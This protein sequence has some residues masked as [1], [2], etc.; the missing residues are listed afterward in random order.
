M[1]GALFDLSF[2]HM[3]TVKVVKIIYLLSL[4]PYTML[5]LLL[6]GYGLDWLDQG[7]AFG[8]LLILTAPFLWFFLLLAT[9]IVLEFVINQFKISEYLRAIKDKR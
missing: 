7:S 3:V 2:D 9:R 8:Y 1:L 5:A 4:V 6:A